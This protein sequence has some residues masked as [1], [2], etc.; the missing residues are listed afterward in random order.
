MCGLVG[1]VAKLQG[2]FFMSDV[3]MFSQ[4]LVADSVRGVD[5]TGV[6]GTY[7]TGSVGW[8][9]VGS[10][11]YALLASKKFDS[12]AQAM[13]RKFD[14]V[15]GHNRKATA[16]SKSNENAHPFI[17]EHIILVHNGMVHNHKKMGDTEVDSHAIAHSF[18]NKGHEET[19]ANLDGAFA[20]IWFDMKDRTLRMV[21]NDQRPL[22]L[23]ETPSQIAFASEGYMLR[24]IA[25]RNNKDWKDI[26]LL[27][28]GELVSISQ[29]T[30]T[31]KRDKVKLYTFTYTPPNNHYCGWEYGMGVDPDYADQ[32]NAEVKDMMAEVNA[33]DDPLDEDAIA[34]AIRDDMPELD[35]DESDEA[36]EFI[37]KYKDG[38]QVLFEPRKLTPWN[39][40]NPQIVGFNIEGV[41]RGDPDV[42]VRCAFDKGKS[43]V[44]MQELTN[45]HVLK[46]TVYG[47]MVNP[48][49]GKQSLHVM[50]VSGLETYRT[51]NGTRLTSDEWIRICDTQ[52]CCR[53]EAKILIKDVD[54]TSVNFKSQGKIR[55]FCHECVSKHMK[56]LP[57]EQQ[58]QINRLN[59]HEREVLLTTEKEWDLKGSAH[60]S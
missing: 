42:S 37:N 56:Q 55:V 9:K 26:K 34:A 40:V 17:H 18:V 2:G 39:S 50:N 47:A 27:P 54:I 49:T 11:P 52:R 6:F 15:V 51:F 32:I 53:C 30:K 20:L 41:L 59:T 13:T 45:R 16:G 48:M 3:S 44:Q 24:W 14:M 22:Y 43:Y 23:V 36:L 31:I 1:L 4:M 5:G 10:H 38:V 7:G 21:R 25:D 8:C 28:P 35:E 60:G 29:Q 46:G 19:L 12:F 57:K 58:E 33:E